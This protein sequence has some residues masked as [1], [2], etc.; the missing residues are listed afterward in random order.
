MGFERQEAQTRAQ[1][2]QQEQETHAFDLYGNAASLVYREK[3]ELGSYRIK[4]EQIDR[5][6]HEDLLYMMSKKTSDKYC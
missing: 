2:T 1:N 4:R 3:T 5:A 6:S